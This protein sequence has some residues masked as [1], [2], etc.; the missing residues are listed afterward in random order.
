MIGAAIALAALPLSA[1]GLWAPF[2]SGLACGTAAAMAGFAVACVCTER[3]VAT[4]SRGAAFAGIGA[5]IFIYL[6]A[7]SSMT[8]LFGMWPGVG[9]AAG[10][11]AAPLAIIVRNVAVPRLRGRLARTPGGRNSVRSGDKS[12]SEGRQY[13]YEPHIRGAD[14]ALRYVF[15]GGPSMEKA[16]GGRIYITHR[17]FRRLAAIRGGKGAGE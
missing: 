3:A 8:F 4:G 12:S 13:I 10:C 7:M 2:A 9:A 6:G 11:L 16:S 15:I 5:R 17:R 14:G 1:Y